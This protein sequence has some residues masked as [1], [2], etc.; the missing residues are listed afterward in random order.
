MRLSKLITLIIALLFTVTSSI[1]QD[2]KSKTKTLYKTYLPAGE[3]ITLE[4]TTN[5]ET[6]SNAYTFNLYITQDEEK[7]N[8]W[9]K[10]ID[11]YTASKDYDIEN[12]LKFHDVSLLENYLFIVYTFEKEIYFDTIEKKE[13]Y[14]EDPKSKKINSELAKTGLSS[15]NIFQTG[16]QAYLFLE[17]S[18]QIREYW[19]ATAEPPKLLWSSKNEESRSTNTY[20]EWLEYIKKRAAEEENKKKNKTST[21]SN[22]KSENPKESANTNN[23]NGSAN[24][25]SDDD[26]TNKDPNNKNGKSDSDADI[27]TDESTSNNSN[28]SADSDSQNPDDNGKSDLNNENSDNVNEKSGNAMD[29]SNFAI[30]AGGGLIV[31]ILIT[32]IF[33]VLSRRKH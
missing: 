18:A 5:S 6:S 32:V 4:R 27:N 8:I 19:H 21:D 2:E 17:D 1:A 11:Q 14:W 25:G 7:T 33:I 12:T 13:A 16:R 15:A 29:G 20:D 22:S 9:T 24:G 10:N 26:E 30:Y 3:L 23:S 28:G 31:L